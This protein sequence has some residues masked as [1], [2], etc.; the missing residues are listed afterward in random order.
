MFCGE[1]DELTSKLF[2]TFF[3]SKKYFLGSEN[4]LVE[5]ISKIDILEDFHAP[6]SPNPI[7]LCESI[8][9]PVV[10]QS[11]FSKIQTFLF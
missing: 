7:L 2:K 4:E 5:V 9:K 6:K 11:S 10:N 8:R 3:R 1:M